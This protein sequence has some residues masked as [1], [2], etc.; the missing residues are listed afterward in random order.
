MTSSEIGEGN[1]IKEILVND[2]EGINILLYA[3]DV[4]ISQTKEE[5]L[6]HSLYYLNKICKE[7]D[8]KISKEKTKVMAFLGKS[9]IRSKIILE[10]QTIEQV[11][12]FTYLGC[13]FTTG[14]ETQK[15]IYTKLSKFQQV[16]GTIHRTLRQK[17]RKETRI[18]FYK[19][20]AVPLLLYGSE[21]WVINKK[22]S[23]RIQ[24]AEMSFLRRTKGCTRL[25]HIQNEDIRNE[26]QIYAIHDKIQQYRNNWKQHL[27]RMDQTRLPRL[28]FQYRPT[29]HRDVGRPRKRWREML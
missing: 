12:N 14:F 7:Y 5:D 27:Y 15:D 10:D 19:T 4:V 13:E 11:P 23:S 21:T 29:G 28:V 1:L 2:S 18:K 22:I 16:C 8:F 24:S 9:N 6:Q 17:T 25:D 3:D 20:M 26:L